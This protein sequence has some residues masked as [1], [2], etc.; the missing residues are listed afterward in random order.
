M[1][2]K[3]LKFT[4]AILIL[5]VILAALLLAMFFPNVFFSNATGCTGRYI[6]FS[7]YRWCVKASTSPVGPGPN[8]FSDNPENIRVDSSG[9]LHLKITNRNNQW[10]CA[11]VVSEKSFGYGTYQFTLGP[12][13]VSFD[14]NIVLGLFTWDDRPD[15]AHREIDIEL[16]RWE[17][18]ENNNS[19]YVVQP[20]NLPGNMLRFNTSQEHSGT[21]HSFN[22]RPDSIMFASSSSGSYDS[23]PAGQKTPDIIQEWTYTGDSIPVAGGENARIN[24]W[25]VYGKVPTDGKEREVV[26][27]KFRFFPLQS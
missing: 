5:A 12:G 22:W 10:Q 7:G 6:D 20:W 16:S 17:L 19:Q 9:Y 3:D 27:E 11:E 8:Y 24:L 25:L 13:A 21:I 18:A 2:N 14:P 1:K 23:N 15:Y 4:S 26:I